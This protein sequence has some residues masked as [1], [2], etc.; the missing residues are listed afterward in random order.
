M[1]DGTRNNGKKTGKGNPPVEH[2]FKPGNPGRPKGARNK[3][4]EMF[5]EDMLAAWESKG[6]AAIHTVI[7]K[8]PQDFLKVVASLMPKDLNV[9]INQIGEMTDEQ[10]LDRIRKLDATIQPFLSAHGEDGNSDGDRTP[11]AH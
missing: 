1:T 8:R 3:L 6:A 7:E 9:N 4:G 10:L 2:Q 5:I 11:T